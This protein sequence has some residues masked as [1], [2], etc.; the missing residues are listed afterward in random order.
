VH[1]LVLIKLYKIL[2]FA[3]I[4]ILISSSLSYSVLLLYVSKLH[5]AV[6]QIMKSKFRNVNSNLS[7]SDNVF[8][9]L[10]DNSD[11]TWDRYVALFSYGLW[12]AVAI[13]VC[14]LCVCLALTNYGHERNRSL[15]VH[16]IFFYVLGCLCLQGAS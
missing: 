2:K 16:A 14:V 7:S 12:L 5:W 15:T 3:F 13:G 11:M 8:I 4:L 6:L 10:P 9:R 1:E